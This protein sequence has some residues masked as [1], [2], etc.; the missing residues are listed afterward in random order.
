MHIVANG[1]RNIPMYLDDAVGLDKM[2]LPHVGTLASLFATLLLHRLKWSPSKSR[3]G[4]T[5]VYVLKPCHNVR[6]STTKRGHVFCPGRYLH[7]YRPKK[8]H[9]PARS[10]K[11]YRQFLAKMAKRTRPIVTF[12]RKGPIFGFTPGTEATVPHLLT[13]LASPPVFIFC[14]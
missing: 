9:R 12:Q 11:Y 4:A 2:P 8:T 3:I 14:Q 13:D 10:L 6:L 5:T 1:L 7:A